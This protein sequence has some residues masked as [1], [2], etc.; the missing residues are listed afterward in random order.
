MSRSS[1]SI[2]PC[3]NCS[4]LRGSPITPDTSGYSR[5]SSRTT[6][7][8]QTARSH[9]PLYPR[10][11]G[12][13]P[14]QMRTPCAFST[15][16]HGDQR[17]R[18]RRSWRVPR[19]RARVEAHRRAPPRARHRAQDAHALKSRERALARELVEVRAEHRGRREVR[20]TLSRH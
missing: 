12:T 17:K 1:T 18:G 6:E 15:G 16:H 5:R 2:R 3:I 13:P 11:A 9:Q 19:A 10:G 4:C 8:R 14:A 20:H 7:P